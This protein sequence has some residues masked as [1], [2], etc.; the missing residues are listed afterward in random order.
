[1]DW[2]GTILGLLAIAGTVLGYLFGGR[3]ERNRAGLKN[4]RR[5]LDIREK[6]D[7]VEVGDDP[8]AARRF[9]HELGKR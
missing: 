7:E 6:Q 4:A 8:A 3:A 2:I 5:E 1:M 9:L